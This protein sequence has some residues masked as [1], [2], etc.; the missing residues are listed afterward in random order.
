M[1]LMVAKKV[2]L[3]NYDIGN[4]VRWLKHVVGLLQEQVKS[5]D[6]DAETTLTNYLA[7]NYNNVLRIKS[8]EDA[9]TVGKN[10][11]DHLVIP[12]ATPRISL[13]ARYEYDV[14]MLF[15]YM[16][17]LKE[18]CIKQQINYEGFIDSLKRGRTKA[19]IDKKRMGKGT[20]M[21]LPAAD[22]LWVNCEGFL[23]D[24]REEEIAAAAQHKATL[25]GDA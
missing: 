16:K 4:T 19:K 24:D 12:D 5:M 1:G 13:I 10:D 15:L 23:D 8:T 3:I 20:R 22:V 14:K 6:V 17:P 2:G 25:E 7:E 9:R 18:W 21:S 11:L